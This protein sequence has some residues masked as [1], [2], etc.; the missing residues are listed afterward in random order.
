MSKFYFHI[1]TGRNVV[2]DEEGMELQGIIAAQAEA[3]ASARDVAAAGPSK[4]HRIIRIIDA[5]GEV[6]GSVPI[7]SH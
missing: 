4:E 7:F 2:L 6:I 3:L 5:S 1:V